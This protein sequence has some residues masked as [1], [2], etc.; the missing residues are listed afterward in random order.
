VSTERRA[1]WKNRFQDVRTW[2]NRQIEKS[3][4]GV[5]SAIVIKVVDQKCLEGKGD[6]VEESIRRVVGK[7]GWVKGSTRGVVDGE[8]DDDAGN[9]E[10][11][12][13]GRG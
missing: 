1:A 5:S 4:Q 9:P 2:V 10:D 13:N 12:M 6:R 11:Q 8:Q 3:K 7:G